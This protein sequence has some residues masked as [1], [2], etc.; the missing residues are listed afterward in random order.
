MIAVVNIA[1]QQ[2]K[3]SKGQKLYVHRQEAETGSQV[4][5]DQVLMLINGEQTTIG[6]PNI[7][8][9]SISAKVLDHIKGDK[10]IVFKKKRRKG[11]EKK[12][13]HRQC[14]TQIQVESI[15]I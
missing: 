1:G 5:F 6:M 15:Q 3:V 11:Y 10:V 7:A 8:G 12:N 2:F 9:A 13:G 4:N 14:F